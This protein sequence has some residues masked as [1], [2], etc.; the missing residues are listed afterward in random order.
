M[1][2]DTMYRHHLRKLDVFHTYL[3]HQTEIVRLQQTYFALLIYGKREF[4]YL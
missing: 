1:L 4:V 2:E 3:K